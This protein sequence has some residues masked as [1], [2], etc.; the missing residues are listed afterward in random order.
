MMTPTVSKFLLCFLLIGFSGQA[1]DFPAPLPEVTAS[2]SASSDTTTTLLIPASQLRPFALHNSGYWSLP[3][4]SAMFPSYGN[5]VGFNHD[6]E[7]GIPIGYGEFPSQSDNQYVFSS[8]LWIG[9]IVNGDTLVSNAYDNQMISIREFWPPDPVAGGV[10]RSG[11]F[12]DDEFVAVY[13]DTVVAPLNS[14]YN[15]FDDTTH[16][17]L[18]LKVTQ[19]SYSWQDTLYDN[20]VIIKFVVENI[21][22]NYIDS[23]WLGIIVDPDIYARNG[24]YASNGW[25]DDAAGVLDTQLY[26]DD[27]GSRVLIPYAYDMDGDPTLVGT[28]DDKSVTGVVSIALL[29]SPA[30]DPV[31]NFNWWITDRPERDFGPRRIGTA[32]DPFRPFT[33]GYLGTAQRQQDKYYVLSHPE[34]D[35]NQIELAV[36]DSTD[37]WVPSP[38]SFDETVHDIKFL[39]SM[40]PFVMAPGDTVVAAVAFV[41]SD[42]F[43]V[44]A[45]DFINLFDPLTPEAFQN[46]LDFSELMINHRRADSVYRSGLTLPH[47]GPPVGMQV[48][49]RDREK[50]TL[51]WNKSQNS[52]LEGYYVYVKDTLYDNI[53]RRAFI[54]PQTD[55]VYVFS[56]SNPS[57]AHLFSVTSIDT[58]GRESDFSSPIA[59]IPGI[60]EPPHD[61][62]VAMEGM[63]PVLDWQPGS[64]TDPVV[65]MIYRSIWK[66]AY[67]LHDS[68]SGLTYHDY[69]AE[70]GVG[71]NYKVAAKNDWQLESEA[72]GPVSALPMALDQG[73]LFYDLNYDQ[74][75]R[76]DP[77]HRRY[78]DRLVQA[79]QP[80]ISMDYFDIESGVLSFKNMS[81][82]SV[83]V[84]DAEKRGGKIQEALVDSI[85]NYMAEGGK[86]V[87]IIPN[88]STHDIGV[89]E[90]KSRYL[91]G[92]LFHDL[93]QLDSAMT[94]RIV[95]INNHLHGDLAGCR[96][97]APEYPDLAADMTKL[98]VAPIPIEGL[99]PLSGYMYPREG[100][101]YLYRYQ[102][103]YP[104]SSY[105]EQVNG[106]RYLSDDYGFVFL[107][108]P[109]SLMEAPA[110]V[111]AFRQALTDLGVDLTCGDIN[112]NQQ[113]DVGDAVVVLA[114]LFKSQ[115][116][117]TGPERADVNCDG[118]I[119]VADAVVIINAVFYDGVELN[120]CH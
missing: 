95:L 106:I 120:C 35:Y 81:H 83:I 59:V 9:G 72:I 28:W 82:Y 45:N 48:V 89:S 60:P 102:S 43:H 58:L 17:P 30:P 76:V 93:L 2:G 88:A 67:Q 10:H 39:Y 66:E 46:T 107:N 73:V 77:Y 75:V 86:A 13:T 6:P 5:N 16:I 118:S 8:G 98:E 101:E 41:A 19:Y 1:A 103:I 84:F 99:I 92:N 112:D 53:W 79:V 62:S 56:V 29:E 114:Y 15:F 52:T 24:S 96:S 3:I 61:L 100:V 117:P 22:G 78:V 31:C 74:S 27:P 71:Y 33:G 44:D 64:D 38:V 55:T 90:Y 34:V 91:E 25:A 47:P 20:F 109:L 63:V 70:S 69:R 40:G 110:N 105:H 111:I 51:T 37:G 23:A 49:D 12:A 116:L 4:A 97:L 85:R 50:V 65:Y 14:S 26:D 57:H 7:T 87:F 21:G 94:N 68:V 36:H 42:G 80:F 113:L 119:D 11:N 32:E 115:P 104:D 18:G 54:Q 108:F